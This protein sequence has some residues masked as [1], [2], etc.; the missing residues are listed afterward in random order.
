MKEAAKTR[1]PMSHE[2]RKK[3]AIKASKR[4]AGTVWIN[5]G[6]SS[7]R[8]PADS[9]IKSGWKKGRCKKQD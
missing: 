4:T 1:K 8:V 6:V 3:I 7:K 5:N 9:L 2:A